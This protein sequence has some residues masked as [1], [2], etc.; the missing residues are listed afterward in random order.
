MFVCFVNKAAYNKMLDK[1]D[2]RLL[3]IWQNEKTNKNGFSRHSPR[4]R[5][6]SSDLPLCL[7][8]LE[9]ML[10]EKTQ[11]KLLLL[12]LFKISH[13][14]NHFHNVCNIFCN[15][16]HPLLLEQECK[17][18]S[19]SGW[20]Q[21]SEWGLHLAWLLRQP[22]PV[23]LLERNR[24]FHGL[25]WTSHH[26]RWSKEY[27]N[28]RIDRKVEFFWVPIYRINMYLMIIESYKFMQLKRSKFG[29]IIGFFS[30]QVQWKNKYNNG[31]IQ[32]QSCR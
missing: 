18:E 2:Y 30:I 25:S 19:F 15:A 5:S 24:H 20:I 11:K 1:I 12:H 29:L 8:S 3:C 31:K 9:I 10:Q 16:C 4:S 7:C 28:I 21:K 32:K 26:W 17:P 27:C 14:R 22:W 13:F 6:Q 23:A